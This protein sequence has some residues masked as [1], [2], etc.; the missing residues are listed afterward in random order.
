MKGLRSS[1]QLADL[2][3]KR[4]GLLRLIQNWRAVQLVYIP[5]VASLLAQSSSAPDSDT[6]TISSTPENLAEN[7]PLLLPSALPHHIR[8]LPELA[9]VCKL[10]QRLRE[11]QADDAL[12]SIQR[13]RRVIQGLWQFKRLNA[14]GIGNR[15]NTKM[16]TL[17]KRFDS[18]TKRA[19][20]EYRS[21]WRALRVL[22]PNGSWSIRLKEL[23][24]SDISG[25]G[26]DPEDKTTT[27]SRYNPSWIW[28]VPGATGTSLSAAQITNDE[29]HDSMRVEWAKARARMMRWDE[30][31][32]I[33]QEEMRRVIEYLRWKAVWWQARTSLRGH[34][35]SGIVSG[36][37]GYANKQAAICSRL[38]ERCAS[39]WVPR[40]KDK[41]IT[42]SWVSYFPG[43]P[44]QKIRPRDMVSVG[45]TENGFSEA[46]D[47]DE[48][49]CVDDEYSDFEGDDED[50]FDLDG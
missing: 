13:Q 27:N 25:P 37:S 17:Y 47:V 9:E 5:H 35:D 29:F 22:D 24:D 19:A 42:P 28:L 39:Y 46:E 6:T 33:V 32:L 10:E 44:L 40:L 12:A 31:L 41:D 15:P 8:N 18:K 2:Q 3:E 30:E 50:N 45:E 14:S 34:S 16:L 20:E 7:I 48:E 38:A 4:N 21:A 36:I 43:L 11:P 1:K 49:Y 26:K 23:K